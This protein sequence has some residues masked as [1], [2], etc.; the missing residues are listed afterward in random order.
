MDQKNLFVATF[1]GCCCLIRTGYSSECEIPARFHGN[2]FTT[3]V[4]YFDQI[5]VNGTHITSTLK[6][7]SDD[8]GSRPFQTE[9]SFECQDSNTVT[10]VDDAGFDRI[11][12]TIKV[13]DALETTCIQ[14][15]NLTPESN[16][17]QFSNVEPSKSKCPG[18]FHMKQGFSYR[19][20]MDKTVECYSD[21]NVF[22]PIG[23]GTGLV[24]QW[25]VCNETDLTI[26]PQD[27]NATVDCIGVWPDASGG[28]MWGISASDEE[29]TL[30]HKF[31][32]FWHENGRLQLSLKTEDC[33]KK[34]A[35]RH[36]FASFRIAYAGTV[37]LQTTLL[38]IILGAIHVL[39]TN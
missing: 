17:M 25:G 13:R 12:A 16:I 29:A 31:Q 20:E 38:P 39:L 3:D 18:P 11:L 21:T 2:F 24:L 1:I 36:A 28:A 10:D 32:C 22:H 35:E 26:G 5:Q 37:A 7:E 9:W 15:M 23:N 34:F 8:K 33:S 14:L 30:S 27:A 6:E 19:G 4:K